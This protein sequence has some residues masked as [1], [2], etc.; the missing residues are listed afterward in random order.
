VK[1]LL[2]RKSGAVNRRT[3]VYLQQETA[4]RLAAWCER[5]HTDKSGVIDT[6]VNLLLDKLVAGEG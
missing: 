6:A 3:T 5:R 4:D 2:T 1:V